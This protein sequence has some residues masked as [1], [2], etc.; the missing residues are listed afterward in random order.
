MLHHDTTWRGLQPAR[1]NVPSAIWRACLEEQ[2]DLLACVGAHL[3]DLRGGDVCDDHAVVHH[4]V[5]PLRLALCICCN[6]C[7]L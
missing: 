7:P 1:M 5:L 2:H 6:A 4:S 3:G